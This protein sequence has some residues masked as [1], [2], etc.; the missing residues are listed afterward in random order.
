MWADAD[1][2]FGRHFSFQRSSE[3]KLPSTDEFFQSAPFAVDEMKTMKT[4]LNSTKSK[5]DDIELTSWHRHTRETNPAGDVTRHLKRVVKAE[6]CT[7]AWAK[8][9]EIVST[10]RLVPDHA[11]GTLYTVHLCEAPGAFVASLNHYLKSHYVGLEWQW[12]ASTLNPFYEGNSPIST[13]TE[14]QFI[15]DTL[16]QWDFGSDNSG[17]VMKWTNIISLCERCESWSV[18]LV[19][20]DGSVDCQ[21][22]PAEQ[23][24]HVAP[25]HYSETMAALSLLDQGGSFVIKMFTFFEHQTICLLYLLCCAFQQVDVMKP[26]TSKGGNSEVYVVCLGYKGKDV[27]GSEPLIRLQ[28]EVGVT[29]GSNKVALFPEHLIAADALGQIIEC[30][31]TFMNFQTEAIERNLCLYFSM[32]PKERKQLLDLKKRVVEVYMAKYNVKRLE[33]DKCIVKKHFLDG[34]FLNSR[35]GWMD[36]GKVGFCGSYRQRQERKAESWQDR[37]RKC[38]MLI[39]PTKKHRSHRVYDKMGKSESIEV[40]QY[41]SNFE[42]NFHMDTKL[43]HLG[44]N[45]IYVFSRLVICAHL[46][47]R[48]VVVI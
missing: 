1:S 22:V 24:S 32:K 30:A 13:V 25:L 15:I 12:M 36:T 10:Y 35:S 8:F 45:V 19:T 7:Q 37:V 27:V 18:Q 40:I 5:L 17:N 43:I 14:D 46:G 23:E 48:A 6:L 21:D 44:I 33:Q 42:F 38:R 34:N 9:H 3:W 47:F 31:G 41:L 2:Y 20:A 39:S 29:G 26:A 4:N 11:G 16:E 28:K